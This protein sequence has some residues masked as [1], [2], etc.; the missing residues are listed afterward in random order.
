LAKSYIIKGINEEIWKDFKAACAH[1]GTTVRKN[2]LEHIIAK[3]QD[4]HI[5]QSGFFDPRLIKKEKR[6]S[7]VYV[8]HAKRWKEAKEDVD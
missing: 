4:Y 8:S 2:L 1:E 6:K 7:K 5:Y 3:V